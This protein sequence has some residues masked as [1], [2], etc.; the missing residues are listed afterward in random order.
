MRIEKRKLKSIQKIKYLI[1]MTEPF[2]L[3]QE[4]LNDSNKCLDF[5]KSLE[6]KK[7]TKFF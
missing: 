1:N 3:T 6:K 5:Y 2:I 7:K 4:V